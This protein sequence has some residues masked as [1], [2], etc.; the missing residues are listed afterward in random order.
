MGIGIVNGEFERFDAVSFEIDLSFS[1][2][3]YKYCHSKKNRNTIFV[4]FADF[5]GRKTGR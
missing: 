4:M 2:M 3:A 1:L 5:F